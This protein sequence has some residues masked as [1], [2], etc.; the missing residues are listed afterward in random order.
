[1][2]HGRV[3][4]GADAGCQADQLAAA[5]ARHVARRRALL[6]RR[7]LRRRG[8]AA[9]ARGRCGGR[10]LAQAAAVAGGRRVARCQRPGGV[11]GH[12]AEHETTVPAQRGEAPWPV[13]QD[14]GQKPFGARRFEAEYFKPYLAHASIGTSCAIAQVGRRARWRY[15]RTARASTTCA[16]T[17]CSRSPASR[18]AG[19]G[20]HHD[21]PRR[22]LGL[23]W[24]QRRRRRGF[25]CRAD[26]AAPRRASRCACCGRAPTS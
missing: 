23:L 5:G 15:G 12:C 16:T 7:Q 13:E 22:R 26:G 25:R 18:P 21:P 20:R 4:R 3:L 6:G 8:G 10:A 2:L 11:A 1:M 14:D 9:R 17:S 24:P 19:Q